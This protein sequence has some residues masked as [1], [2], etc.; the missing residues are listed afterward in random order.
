[1]RIA[2]NRLIKKAIPL[3]LGD[4]YQQY[5]IIGTNKEYAELYKVE[6]DKGEW[7]NQEMEVTIGANVA[8]V[9]N[10]SVGTDF[11]STHGLTQ[12][13]P[14]HEEQHYVVKGILKRSNTVLDNLI[15]T[16]VESI[17]HVHEAHSESKSIVKQDTSF[18]PSKLI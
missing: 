3:A 7:W 18:I 12:G 2:K 16:S 8:E 10:F 17:W 14:G 5:R 13:G 6:L 1:E 9:L 15:L 4:S 11:E